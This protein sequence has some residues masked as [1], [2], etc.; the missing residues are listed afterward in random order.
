MK[1]QTRSDV[2]LFYVYIIPFPEA[3]EAFPVVVVKV[4]DVSP[5]EN[6]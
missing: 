4:L 3:I 6:N 2:T 1:I 5:K